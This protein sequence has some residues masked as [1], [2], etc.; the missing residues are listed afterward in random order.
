[1]GKEIDK[2]VYFRPCIVVFLSFYV[3]DNKETLRRRTVSCS[4]ETTFIRNDT[5]GLFHSATLVMTL[6]SLGKLQLK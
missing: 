5:C 4:S 2:K 6:F 1:M 3:Q